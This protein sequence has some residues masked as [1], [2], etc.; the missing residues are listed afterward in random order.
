MKLV[1]LR[2]YPEG[3]RLWVLEQRVHH[4]A[5]GLALMAAALSRPRLRMAAVLG[6]MLALHDRRDWK[7]WFV[8]ELLP[9]SVTHR[10]LEPLDSEL[11]SE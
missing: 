7:V 10:T 8:R 1:A 11:S 5:T 6:A 9:A 4:G 3:P 2:S